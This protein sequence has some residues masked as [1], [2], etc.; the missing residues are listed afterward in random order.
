[1]ECREA[2][3]ASYMPRVHEEAVRLTGSKY[4]ISP[5]L[6]TLDGD[7]APSWRL[8]GATPPRRIKTNVAG[9]QYGSIIRRHKPTSHGGE[10]AAMSMSI[11]T[12]VEHGGVVVVVVRGAVESSQASQLAD[13]I[14]SAV[15]RHRPAV[16]CLDL[17]L[18]TYVDST[19]VGAVVAG[20]RSAG[21]DGTRLVIRAMSPQ[22]QRVFDV[23][24]VTAMLT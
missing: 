9:Q 10:I 22:V 16:L 20:H 11:T 8:A 23:S 3:S 7:A 17:G 21:L 1:M 18:V 13:A 24:G 12:H 2:W 6:L 5:R 15:D 4:R 19:A 14:A